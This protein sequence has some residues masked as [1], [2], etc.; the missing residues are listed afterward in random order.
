MGKRDLWPDVPEQG[1]I[2]VDHDGDVAI[3]RL[4]GEHDLA[5]SP[6]LEQRIRALIDQEFGIAVDLCKTEFIDAAILNVLIWANHELTEKRRADLVLLINT[7]CAVER[8]LEVSGLMATLPCAHTR[9][10]A[11][12]LARNRE[13]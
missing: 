2:E 11:I 6:Q 8:A 4:L 5:S 10:G 3:V 9:S 12:N 7:E 13:R 1:T